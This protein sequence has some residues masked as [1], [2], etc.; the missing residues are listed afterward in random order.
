[1]DR[2][3]KKTVVYRCG[4]CRH[5]YRSARAAREC[6]RRACEKKAHKKG[7]LVRVS[8]AK[9]TCVHGHRYECR[10]EVRRVLG[11]LPYDAEIFMKGF[12]VADSGLHKYLYE[13]PCACPECGSAG[14]GLYPVELL[15]RAE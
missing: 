1:M 8:G 15:E 14:G 10:G 6:E 4:T 2:V 11:P 7:D 13:V 5:E 3:V 12:G 9:R